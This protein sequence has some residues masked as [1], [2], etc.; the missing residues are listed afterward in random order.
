VRLLHVEQPAGE[1]PD[2]PLPEY[3]LYVAL[4]GA[5][6]LK[7]DWGCGRWLGRWHAGDVSLAPPDTATD[8]HV[9][10][11]HAF[12][13]LAL[14]KALVATALDE[15]AVRDPG[16]LHAATFRDRLLA[17]LCHR[18]WRNSAT[19]D[20]LEIDSSIY[21][22]LSVLAQR[23]ACVPAAGTLDGSRLKRVLDGIE[24]RLAENLSLAE[25]AATGGLSP[26]HFARQFKRR[27]GASPHQYVL[28]RRLA[29][30]RALLSA[31]RHCLAEIALA[32]GFASQAHMTAQFARRFGITPA[33]Y[34]AAVRF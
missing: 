19:E 30:A 12:L 25:L 22:I 2:P 32:T 24:E 11:D 23:A 5:T 15:L 8:I 17:R 27:M 9:D 4:R 3:L 31:G 29:R 18:L 20:K 7:F 28:A 6:E 34:R 10:R 16:P 14:P 21:A 1:F 26:M 33:R 13:G